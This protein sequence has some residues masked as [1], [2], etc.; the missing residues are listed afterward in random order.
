MG[1]SQEHAA[2]GC[3]QATIGFCGFYSRASVTATS[4]HALTSHLH[5][6]I[7]FNTARKGAVARNWRRRGCAVVALA[8]KAP[9]KEWMGTHLNIKLN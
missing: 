7:A 5:S 2:L 9:T 4:L 8:W 3:M 1:V 6:Y